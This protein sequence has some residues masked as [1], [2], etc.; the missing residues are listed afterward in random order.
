M[1]EADN[2]RKYQRERRRLSIGN[3]S[4]SQ[5]A[6]DK[7]IVYVDK[8]GLLYKLITSEDRFCFLARPRTFGHSLTCNT[9]AKLFEGCRELFEGLAISRT[10]YDFKAYPVLQFDL[11]VLGT[12][13][14]EGLKHEIRS[15]GR[16]QGIGLEDGTPCEMLDKL[17]VQ[18][19]NPVIIIDEY[20]DALIHAVCDNRRREA[21]ALR[22]EFNDFY[23]TILKHKE[24]IRF[25]FLTGVNRLSGLSIFSGIKDLSSEPEYAS[26]L[27]YTEDE[28]E[29]CFSDH[30]EYYL[31]QEDRKCR[32]REELFSA[33]RRNYGG[34]RFS[35]KSEVKVYNP[36]S[37]ARFFS[38]NRMDFDNYWSEA[39]ALST[40]PFTMARKNNLKQLEYNELRI[41]AD[42]LSSFDLKDITEAGMEEEDIM[43]I[44]T[45]SYR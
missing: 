23:D 21:E 27:G 15:Q 36:V 45:E 37:I 6:T 1:T 13:F 38:D 35:P 4:F 44:R 2:S 19:E 28:L 11:S 20:D 40:L 32:T 30:I 43:N 7:N 12:D 16:K 29:H 41:S 26:L 24:K 22:S 31:E 9:L 39:G 14:R 25:L 3:P 18:L 17:L 42:Y 8:S 5:F 10:D 33:L 34:Y